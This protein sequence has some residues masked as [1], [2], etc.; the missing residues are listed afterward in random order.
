MT[1]DKSTKEFTLGGRSLQNRATLGVI[2]MFVGLALYPF[3]DACIK[4]LTLT[5]S[6]PQVTF[7][8]AL[9]RVFPLL[10]A[11]LFQ[12]GL[13]S[14]LSTAHPRRHAVRLAVNLFYTYLFIQ[15]Y[16][17]GSLTAIYTLA[18]T[19]PFFMIVLSALMLKEPVSRSRWIAV[20]IGM[21]GVFIA[22]HPTSGVFEWI[23]VVVLL[24]TFLGALNKILMR[25]L[26]AT[27]HS[28]AITIYPNLAMILVLSPI[29]LSTWKAMPWEHWA[30]FAFVGALAAAGQYSIAQALRFAQ[31]STLAPIDYSSFFWVVS[32]DFFWWNKIPDMYTLIGATVIVG[33]NLY[34]LYKTRR[35]E[36][37]KPGPGEAIFQTVSK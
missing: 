7:L 20:A 10:I 12:G 15:A 1:V 22:M 13:F 21:G 32:L 16:T 31:A 3:S 8:R 11:T 25:R 18:Y 36:A 14:A 4:H 28:L 33:S 19:T 2:L 35:E 6:V 37:A 29:L 9:T 5:Y 30:L 24:A 34:I 17:T 23:S 26:A 27:E